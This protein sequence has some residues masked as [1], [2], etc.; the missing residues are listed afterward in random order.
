LSADWALPAPPTG[1]VSP[2]PSGESEQPAGP[3]EYSWVGQTARQIGIVAHRLWGM[4]A[5]EGS[6]H[7]D[8]QRIGALA[9]PT[10]LML[11]ERG[12][13]GDE[14][15]AAGRRI[16]S[17]LRGVLGDPR[18]RWVLSGKHQ[19]AHCEYPLS[20]YLDGR[21]VHARLDRSFVDADGVCWVVDYKTGGHE[22]GDREAFLDQELTRYLPQLG[23]YAALV[24]HMH[25][26]PVCTALYYPVLQGW[27]EWHPGSP[28]AVK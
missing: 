20:G 17:V 13:P 8:A 6:E 2:R 22:G 27:R 4:V 16:M 24:R 10:V 1:I 3:V 26:G 12:V 19:Q 11:R 15:D 23:R 18:G 21:L 14:L 5:Q 9:R 25:D 7:W 28:Q